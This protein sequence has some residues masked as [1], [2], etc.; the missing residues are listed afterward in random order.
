MAAGVVLLVGPSGCGK[1]WVAHRCGLP[2]LAL[3]DFYRPADDQSMPR[4]PGGHPDWGHD[5][6]ARVENQHRG[7]S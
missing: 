3:D 1:T 2:I 5:S 6:C 4:T 7:Y